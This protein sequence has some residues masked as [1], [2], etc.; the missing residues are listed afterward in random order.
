MDRCTA[1]S[2]ERLPG[3]MVKSELSILDSATTFHMR[4]WVQSE[5]VHVAQGYL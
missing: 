2:W 1:V 4:H 5:G 3:H